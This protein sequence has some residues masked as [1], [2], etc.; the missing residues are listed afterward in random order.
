MPDRDCA[1]DGC[2][3]ARDLGGLAT[4]DGRS[5]RFGA[6]VRADHPNMLT[7]A[8]W[9]A[10]YDHGIRT[11]VDLRNDDEIRADAVPRPAG[12]TTV[13]VPLDGVEDTALWARIAADGLDGSPLY[14]PLFLARRPDRCAAAVTAV[15]RAAPGGVLVHCGIGR[16]RTGLVAMLLLR[17]AGVRPDEIAAD[18]LRSTERLAALWP[19]RGLDDQTD[20]IAG[21]LARAGTTA[22][23]ALLAALPDPGYLRTAG[24]AEADL[25]ALR[26]RLLG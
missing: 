1:F 22:R 17:L 11:V 23:E 14:Y 26:T 21:L 9:T 7:A 15:A 8:G 18:Y 25:A 20:E 13:H 6:V 10:V 4:T 5:T 12:V 16:D 19:A 3:N 2:F 24:V